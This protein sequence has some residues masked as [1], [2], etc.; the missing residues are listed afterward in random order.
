MGRKPQLLDPQYEKL[1]FGRCSNDPSCLSA[2]VFLE[3]TKSTDDR[4]YVYPRIIIGQ[5][6]LQHQSARGVL[7]AKIDPQYEGRPEKLA[8]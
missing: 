5:Q 4:L 6:V 3:L 1:N 8:M 2:H 7:V